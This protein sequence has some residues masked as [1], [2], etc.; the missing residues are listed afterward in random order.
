M[1]IAPRFLGGLSFAVASRIY[2]AHGAGAGCN[3][4]EKVRVKI[5]HLYLS[6]QVRYSSGVPETEALRTNKAF[7][8][9]HNLTAEYFEKNQNFFSL[10]FSSRI[11]VSI[12][13]IVVFSCG[14]EVP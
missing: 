7:Q 5:Y 9:F 8:A 13:Y 10:I 14:A 12:A 4:H 1:N 11:L 2:I 3:M 6:K